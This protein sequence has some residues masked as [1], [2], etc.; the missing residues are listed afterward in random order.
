MSDE[1][2]KANVNI[3]SI[4]V[5]QESSIP[6]QTRIN[7]KNLANLDIFWTEEGYSMKTMSQLVGWSI[8]L[9]VDI[10]SNNGKMVNKVKSL[11]E[12]NRY[13]AMRGLYQKG[14]YKKG[15]EKLAT[16]IRFESMRNE[17]LDPETVTPGQYKVIHNKGSIRPMRDV[18]HIGKFN[19]L[20]DEAFRR[21]DEERKAELIRL[22]IE[23]IKD[24]RSAGAIVI[25]PEADKMP[26]IEDVKDKARRLS[27]EKPTMNDEEYIKSV[28]DIVGK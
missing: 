6:V 3:D 26:T 10:L 27:N 7:L 15:R 24:A 12:G 25:D 1:I 4:E 11:A 19:E 5:R 22:K 18:V 21:N 20:I 2:R 23:T 28:E 13:L 16:S 14:M 17:G 8:D 9:L